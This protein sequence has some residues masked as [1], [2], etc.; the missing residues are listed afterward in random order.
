MWLPEG[1]RRS[2]VM[3][4]LPYGTYKTPEEAAATTAKVVQATGIQLVKLEGHVPE[5]V[6][7]SPAE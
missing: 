2:I 4:D 1:A 3:F 6:T 7:A 5:I